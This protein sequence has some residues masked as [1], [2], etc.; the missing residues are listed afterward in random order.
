MCFFKGVLFTPSTGSKR[1]SALPCGFWVFGFPRRIWPVLVLLSPATSLPPPSL[2]KAPLGPFSQPLQWLLFDLRIASTPSSPFP[3]CSAP[4][5]TFCD[6]PNLPM[7]SPPKS[8]AFFEH[9]PSTVGLYAAVIELSLFHF[10]CAL[11]AYNFLDLDE[12]LFHAKFPSSPL[13]PPLIP[14]NRICFRHRVNVL[15][16]PTF[17]G[18]LERCAIRGLIRDMI[19]CAFRPQVTTSC[20]RCWSDAAL[21]HHFGLPA[22]QTIVSTLFCNT[23]VLYKYLSFSSIILPIPVPLSVLQGRGKECFRPSFADFCR[24]SVLVIMILSDSDLIM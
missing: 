5:T 19:V 3:Y 23:W 14:F 15:F 10:F 13:G 12:Y 20:L 17:F 4:S 18:F 8:A 21:F 16:F 11:W 22:P 7:T 1:V 24:L 2:R 6:F 9:I